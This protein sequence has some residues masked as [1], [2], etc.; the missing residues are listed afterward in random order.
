MQSGSFHE[1]VGHATRVHYWSTV[2]DNVVNVITDWEFAKQ[3]TSTRKGG[4]K[5]THT[6]IYSQHG[7]GN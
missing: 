3:L 4:A 7:G 5:F 2:S 6:V 1:R